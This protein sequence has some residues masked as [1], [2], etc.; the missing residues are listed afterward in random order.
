MKQALLALALGSIVAF[1]SGTAQPATTDDWVGIW[2]TD[3]GG[4][5]SGTLTLATDTGQLGGTVVLD[6]ISREDG[7]PHVIASEPHVL[8]SPHVDG[9]TLWFDV[10]MR[11]L[12]GSVVSATFNVTRTAPDRM[13]LHCINC[14]NAP[15]VQLIKQQ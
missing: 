8:V 11:R 10:K 9:N 4:L 13:T 6:I 14:G 3:V 12:N 5:P 7:K 2:H 15:V 1:A